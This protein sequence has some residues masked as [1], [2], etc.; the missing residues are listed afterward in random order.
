M[1]D[2]PTDVC[3][4]CDGIKLCGLTI[5]KFNNK[6]R[7]A[8]CCYSAFIARLLNQEDL[9]TFSSIIDCLEFLRTSKEQLVKNICC[10]CFR[11]YL[12]KNNKNIEECNEYKDF[13]KINTY[14]SDGYQNMLNHPEVFN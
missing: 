2:V 3:D 6:I 7:Y 9:Y 1:T 14:F 10:Y 12:V 5:Y 8:I 11:A 4:R 13:K